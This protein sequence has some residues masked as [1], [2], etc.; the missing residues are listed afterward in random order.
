L[1]DHLLKDTRPSGSAQQLITKLQVPVMKV[2]LADKGF[3]SRRNHPARQLLNT[4]SETSLFWMD[5]DDVDQPLLERMHLV[6]DRVTTDYDQDHSIF[7]S[8][9]GDLNRH[10]NTLQRKAEV[11]EKRNVDAA[12]GRER[13]DVARQTATSEI[14]KRTKGRLLP[15][16]VMQLMEHAWA[17][18]LALTQLREGVDSPDF[19]ER[20]LAVEQLAA[21]FDMEHPTPKSEFQE[22][23]PLLDEG[24]SLVGFAPAEADRTLNAIEELVVEGE[25]LLPSLEPTEERAVSEIV[26]GKGRLGATQDQ[27]PE[28]KT[29]E[30]NI[31]KSIESERQSLLTHLRNK[32]GRLPLNPKEQAM[33]E[34]IKQM[35]FGTWFE[36]TVN[37]QGEK[38][39]RKLSW[40]STVTG[41][42]LFVNARGAKAEERS[43]DRMARERRILD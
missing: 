26:K 1:F 21:C 30:G 39:R 3:F 27:K 19:Q 5:E 20:L 9:L 32:D 40:F 15:P 42:C 17:D 23:R 2:A 24:L 37:Q 43:M 25:A 12:K 38:V 14:D 29:A 4:I 41:R 10:V 11:A 33:V 16:L 7:E 36:F 13:L 8:M 6:I 35:P 34:K 22:L 31:L 28:E 18:L